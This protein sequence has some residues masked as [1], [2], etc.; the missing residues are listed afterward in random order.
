MS[1]ANRVNTPSTENPT[2]PYLTQEERLNV[3]RLLTSAALHLWSKNKKQDDKVQEFLNAIVPLT[4][5]DPYFLAQLTSYLQANADSNK[6]LTT[7][8]T[9]VNSLST[10]DG[11]PFSKDSEFFKPNLRKVSAA[12]VLMLPPKQVLRLL[13]VAGEKWSTEGYFNKGRHFAGS[14]LTAIKKYIQYRERN[15]QMLRGIVKSGLK[16]TMRNLYIKS[17]LA[18]SDEAASILRWKQKDGRDITLEDRGFD[19]ADKDD[20]AVAEEIRSKRVPFLTALGELSRVEKK[21][22]PVIAVALLEQATGDQAVIARKTFEDAGILKDKEV[23]ELYEAKIREAKNALD[24]L[25]AFDSKLNEQTKQMLKQ[26]RADV[27]KEQIGDIG[28]VYLHIDASSSMQHIIEFAKEKSSL[29][30]EMVQNPEKNFR[31]GMYN[32]MSMPLP[33]PRKFVADGFKEVLFS[34]IAMG[35]TDCFALYPTAREFGADVDIQI[36]DGGHNAGDLR[37]KMR[38]YHETNPD[39]PKP[40][41]CVIIDFSPPNLWFDEPGSKN[42][43]KEAYEDNGIPVAVLKPETFDSSALVVDAVKTAIKGPM[44]VIETIMETPLLNLPDWYYLG[45]GGD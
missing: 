10:A 40:R 37:Q 30:A 7:L 33:L 4:V 16:N 34:R 14:L 25:Q 20:L 28:K 41:A 11:T 32:E 45:K 21:I 43:V 5:K 15:P 1:T 13:E 38:L 31:W 17:R 24:R 18:P 27:R 42:P 22:S 29:I 6:D 26:A 9:Y 36:T 44:A 8:V 12:S 35:G 2:L 39:K 19:F 23:K 3:Y